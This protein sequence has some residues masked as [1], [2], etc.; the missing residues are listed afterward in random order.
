MIGVPKKTSERE[1]FYERLSI[2][3]VAPL[4]ERLAGML[5]PEPNT[6]AVAAIWRYDDVR[7]FIMEAGEMITA[8]EA[9]RRV[10]MLENPAL[11][12]QARI[13]QSLYAGLQLILPG[14][15]APAIAIPRRRCALSSRAKAPTQ[16][17]TAKRRSCAPAISSSP[18]RGRGTTMATI[19]TSRWCGSTG[20]IF[21]WFCF[22]MDVR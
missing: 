5:T 14:E 16:P 9:E 8:E 17:W 2:H 20:W 6:S 7:P 12:G 1:A 10:L 3:S 13:T 18:R 4:W 11:R 22:S 21:R 15:I 19:A